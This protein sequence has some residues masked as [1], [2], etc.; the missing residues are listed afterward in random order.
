MKMLRD[1]ASVIIDQFPDT[2]INDLTK[3][4]DR[5]KNADSWLSTSY[6]SKDSFNNLLKIMIESGELDNSVSYED[7]IIN[8]YE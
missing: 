1:I 5:Y 6:I 8:Y 7:L 2:S 3:I 4:I